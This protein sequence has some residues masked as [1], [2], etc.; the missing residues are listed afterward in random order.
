MDIINKNLLH[1]SAISVSAFMIIKERVETV[2]LE[3]LVLTHQSF[4]GYLCIRIFLLV[5]YQCNWIVYLL[6]RSFAFAVQSVI[7]ILR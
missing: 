3:Y 7:K 6:C 4:L 1:Q 2:T 5:P